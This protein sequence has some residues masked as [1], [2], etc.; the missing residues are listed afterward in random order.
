MNKII[1]YLIIGLSMVLSSC[2]QF[3][4]EDFIT[5]HSEIGLTWRGE[6]QI[7]YSAQDCQLGYNDRRNEYRVYDDK[8]SHWFVVRCSEKPSSEGQTLSADVSWT[9]KTEDKS[10]KGISLQV[11]KTD[12]KGKVWL[13]NESEKIGIIIKNQ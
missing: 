13:W 12:D 7:E 6:L 10:L 11:T 5:G 1:T 3:N 8:L 4:L 9:G 2:T